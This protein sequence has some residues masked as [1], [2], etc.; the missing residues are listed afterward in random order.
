MSRLSAGLSSFAPL[1]LS[2]EIFVQPAARNC[3]NCMYSFWPLLGGV[4]VNY[5]SNSSV[6]QIGQAA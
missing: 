1:S 5:P 6:L 3:A 4:H 2:Q